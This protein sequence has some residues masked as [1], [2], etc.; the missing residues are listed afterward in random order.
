M[1]ICTWPGQFIGLQQNTRSS[2]STVRKHV[3][4][5]VLPVARQLPEVLLHH[6][7]RVDFLVA[8][9]L[10]RAAHVGDQ[11]LEQRPALRVP[12]HRA[13]RLFLEMEQVHLAAELAVVALLGLLDLMQVGFELVLGRPRGAVD[14]LQL[15][16]R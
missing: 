6:V 3:L 8:G 11:R 1:K 14:A 4:A 13:R 16:L 2:G 7:G 9:A 12:E 5:V 15:R 10:L